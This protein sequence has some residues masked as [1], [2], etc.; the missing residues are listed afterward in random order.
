MDVGYS[1]PDFTLLALRKQ[2][3]GISFFVVN[4]GGEA[5]YSV[6]LPLTG[7]EGCRFKGYVQSDCGAVN[8]AVGKEHWAVK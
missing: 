4:S 8:N 1:P 7:V 2:W 6:L 5:D 3:R